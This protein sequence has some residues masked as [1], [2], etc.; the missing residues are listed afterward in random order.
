MR[1]VVQGVSQGR[2]LVDERGRSEIAP[3]DVVLVAVDAGWSGP[4]GLADRKDRTLAHL[5]RR[6][7]KNKPS[8]A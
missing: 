7:G 1:A 4:C 3:G 5:Q 8:F 2:V 6:G